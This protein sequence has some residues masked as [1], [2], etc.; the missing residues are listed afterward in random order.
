MSPESGCSWNSTSNRIQKQNSATPCAQIVCESLILHQLQMTY[1]RD[2]RK[3]LARC[4]PKHTARPHGGADD[5][6]WQCYP[7][8]GL[9]R[10]PSRETGDSMPRMRLNAVFADHRHHPDFR[11]SM[12][13]HGAAAAA[14]RESVCVFVSF[15]IVFF[16]FFVFAIRMF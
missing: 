6:V 15:C 9:Q 16:Q 3:P 10:C 7:H 8:A 14:E 4:Q 5:R 2:S 11:I 13:R 1:Q 12:N